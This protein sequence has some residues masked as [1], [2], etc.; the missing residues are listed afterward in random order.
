MAKIPT[1]HMTS[2]PQFGFA[3]PYPS[4]KTGFITPCFE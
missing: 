3:G 1:I 4:D 2:I